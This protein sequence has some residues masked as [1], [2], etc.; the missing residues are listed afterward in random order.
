MGP[1]LVRDAY[2]KFVMH[3]TGNYGPLTWANKDQRSEVMSCLAT[4]SIRVP[5]YTSTGKLEDY[6]AGIGKRGF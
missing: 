6:W 1:R 5:G 4:R 3:T 2:G